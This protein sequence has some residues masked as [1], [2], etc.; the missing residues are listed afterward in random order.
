MREG[1]PN[2]KSIKPRP[3]YLPEQRHE[4]SRTLPAPPLGWLS[5]ASSRYMGSCAGPLVE[6]ESTSSQGVE[7]PLH[8]LMRGSRR[9]LSRRNQACD[10]GVRG[11]GI[12]PE[13]FRPYIVVS[14]AL[15]TEGKR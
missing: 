5:I 6:T 2:S 9:D 11:P 15:I 7:A 4:E 1:T 12:G 14:H 13:T 8:H 3:Y 10:R